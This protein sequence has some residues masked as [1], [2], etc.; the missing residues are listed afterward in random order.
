MSLV[1]V[2]NSLNGYAR[3]VSCSTAAAVVT[4]VGFTATM[5]V[6]AALAAVMIIEGVR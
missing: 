2:Y 3:A 6:A 5:A 4:T 1:T